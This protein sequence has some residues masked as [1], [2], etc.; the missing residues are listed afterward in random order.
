V[1]KEES[2]PGSAVYVP[3]PKPKV[4]DDKVSGESASFAAATGGPSRKKVGRTPA[5]FGSPNPHLETSSWG[6]RVQLK[7]QPSY[8]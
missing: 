3:M 5:S 4:T 7:P 6:T 2:A 1:A 8:A